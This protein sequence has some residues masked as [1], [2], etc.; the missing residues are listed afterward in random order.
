MREILFR[1]KRVDNGEWI[2]G[3]LIQTQYQGK[4]R[5]WISENTDKTRLRSV[6]GV[7]CDW[8]SYEIITETVCQYTGLT[9]KDGYR[10]FENDILDAL[11]YKIR[12]GVVKFGLYKQCDM[13]SGYECGNQGFYVWFDVKKTLRPDI[14][15]WHGN[16]AVVGNIFDNP[17]LMKDG[18]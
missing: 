10:I 9:D 12:K 13:E 18:D 7:R 2:T 4:I 17:E 1:G 15:Y 11:D 14:Y 8:R 5:S 3:D 16:S 6:G